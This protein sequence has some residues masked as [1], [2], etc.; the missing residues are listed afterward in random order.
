MDLVRVEGHD[1]VFPD[2]RAFVIVPLGA[3]VERPGGPGDLDHQLGG[4]AD[5]L[6]LVARLAAALG[7]DAQLGVGLGDAEL[8]H[9]RGRVR[10]GLD[11][12]S[13]GSIHP[14]PAHDVDR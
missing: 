7:Q 14:E 2:A 12:G 6:A 4:T 11:P 8:V 9:Q 13:S 3:E 5:V 10:E 1:D